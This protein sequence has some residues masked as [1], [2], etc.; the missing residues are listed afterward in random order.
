MAYSV[1]GAYFWNYYKGA[2]QK[3]S[4]GMKTYKQVVC[5]EQKSYLV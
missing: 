1:S 4:F 2:W 5:Y 3:N